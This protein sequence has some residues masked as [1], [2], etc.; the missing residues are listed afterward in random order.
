MIMDDRIE[1]KLLDLK[2]EI[3]E[4]KSNVARLEGQKTALMSQLKTE[5]GVSSIKEARTKL[6]ELQKKCDVLEKKI[7]EGLQ[8]LEETYPMEE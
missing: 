4:A 5:W 3:D 1:E 8:E 6:A 2:S 7:K